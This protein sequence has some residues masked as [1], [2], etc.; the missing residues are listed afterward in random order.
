[1]DNSFKKRVTLPSLLKY[2]FPT[3]IMMIFFLILY[4]RRWNVY[5]KVFRSNALSATNI[6]FPV[7]NII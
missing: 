1:M 5:C 3:V 6:V 2:T 7:I 4:N